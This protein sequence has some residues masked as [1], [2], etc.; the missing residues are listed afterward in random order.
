[1]HDA[2]KCVAVMKHCLLAV[3]WI[4][5]DTY[6]GR[7]ICLRG[8]VKTPYQD[9][10]LGRSA[11]LRQEHTLRRL[12]SPIRY[13][14]LMRAVVDTDSRFRLKGGRPGLRKAYGAVCDMPKELLRG[15]QRDAGSG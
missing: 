12:G 3:E 14:L 10:P 5:A 4:F 15:A 6:G 13:G 1:M 8:Q 11:L 7:L 2:P 9:M